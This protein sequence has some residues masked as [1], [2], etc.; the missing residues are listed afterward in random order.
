WKILE[1]KL[2]E[3]PITSKNARSFTRFFFSGADQTN[4]DKQGRVSLPQN[5][6]DY[7]DLNKE[8]V[9]IGLA[10]RIELW[11]KEKWDE[12]MLEAEESHEDIAATMEDLGI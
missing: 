12:F 9:I 7:A 11:S 8:I 3:L 2:K 10:N 1:G 6:R 4:L 5:L